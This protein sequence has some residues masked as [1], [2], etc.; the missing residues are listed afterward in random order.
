MGH[1]ALQPSRNEASDDLANLLRERARS[2]VP[3]LRERE[4]AANA[5]GQVPPE[6]IEDFEQ[7]GFFKILQPARYGGYE[8]SP[9]IY[10][11]VTRILAEGCMSS[12]WVYGVVAVH[13]WQLAL[14]DERAAEDVWGED[15]S[16]RLSSSQMP[17]G[18][19]MRVEGGFRLSGHWAFSSGSAHCKWVILGGMAPAGEGEKPEAL[20]FLVPRPDYRIVENWDVM[21]LRATGSND[22]VVED[23]FVPEYRAIS[24]HSMFMLDC[25]G[26]VAHPAPLYKIPFAQLFNRT[27]A[28]TS[29]GALKRAVEVFI[30]N[31]RAK[32]ATYTGLRLA[33]DPSIQQAVVEAQRTL[34]ELELVL[35]RDLNELTRRAENNDWPIERRAELAVSTTM[36]V[37]RCVTE[38]DKLMQF[39]GGKAIYRGNAMQRAFLDI[40]CARAHAMNNPLPY[41][42]NLAA[43]YFG[44]PNDYEDV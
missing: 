36:T 23:V 17:A 10:C 21:G 42:R 38:V 35:D 1:A 26:H 27:V 20:H 5:G 39:S 19:V 13:N 44:F 15:K 37:S 41:A 28:I 4:A 43:V 2:L 7:A 32:R 24:E 6:T 22:I 40:H 14:F 30:D 34:D 16:V 31:T 9:K 11:D 29:L 8:L 25:P 3:V 18:K 33:N 12:A